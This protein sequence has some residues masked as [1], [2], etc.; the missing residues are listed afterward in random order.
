ML[1]LLVCNGLAAGGAANDARPAVVP[2]LKNPACRR[3]SEITRPTK[4]GVGGHL[5]RR[6]LLRGR[7]RSLWREHV[8]SVQLRARISENG[9]L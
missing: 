1:K 5:T 9:L 6:E 8:E 2:A 4:S 3:H 7:S